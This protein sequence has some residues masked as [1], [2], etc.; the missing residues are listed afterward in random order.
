MIYQMYGPGFGCFFFV[1][2]RKDSEKVYSNQGIIIIMNLGL[3]LEENRRMK[4]K[5]TS[6]L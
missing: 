4:V 1:S 5:D 6:V 2:W 3:G